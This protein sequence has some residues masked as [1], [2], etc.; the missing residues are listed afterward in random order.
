ATVRWR[1]G[2]GAAL[3]GTEPTLVDGQA[4]SSATAVLQQLP[5]ANSRLVAALEQLEAV[6]ENRFVGEQ[7]AHTGPLRDV[8]ER[9]KDA[10]SAPERLSEWVLLV[11]V[12]DRCHDRG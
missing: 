7:T 10:I 1:Q 2:V 8:L 12:L 4:R 5:A 11:E 9:C 6:W 3:S